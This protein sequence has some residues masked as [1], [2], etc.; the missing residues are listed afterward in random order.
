MIR[1]S[2]AAVQAYATF[3]IVASLGAGQVTGT[4][5]VLSIIMVALAAITTTYFG[6]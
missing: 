4:M 1:L 5:A 6:E 3:S 2:T